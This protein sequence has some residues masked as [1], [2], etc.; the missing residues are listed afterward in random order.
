MQTEKQ[1]AAADAVT[2]AAFRAA[3]A[4]FPT[5]VTVVTRYSGGRPYG[6]TVSS[7]TSVSLDPPLVLVCL[8][9]RAG[10]VRELHG[11][12]PFAVNVLR[13][14]QQELAI[15]FSRPPEHRRF[16][17]IHWTSG[18]NGAPLLPGTVAC[19]ECTLFEHTPAGDHLIVVG[20]VERVERS[21]GNPLVWCASSYHCI[22]ALS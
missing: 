10:F 12:V 14:D 13:E 9:K 20:K 8:D 4:L 3:C 5:G 22:P 19:F 6:M 15:R 1:R 2:E 17:H 7:F 16:E 21:A 11:S 18:I